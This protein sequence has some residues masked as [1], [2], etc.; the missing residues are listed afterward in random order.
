MALKRKSWKKISFVFILS[1][2]IA[3]LAGLGSELLMRKSSIWVAWILLFM[4]IGI[5][6]IFDIIGIAATAAIE[7]PHHAKA[8]N[9][10]QGAKQ[11]V[12]LLRNADFVANFCNDIIGDVAG[13][14]SGAMAASILV[15]LI[16]SYPSLGNQEILWNTFLLALVASLTITG[17]ALGKSLAINEADEI[18]SKVGALI[19]KI[20]EI[21]GHSFTDTKKKG[22]KRNGD[23]RKD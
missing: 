5:S 18:M 3:V 14:L 12:Y 22:G 15:D 16:R 21:T 13:T 17:K 4:I 9:R 23:S 11:T 8:A 19:A 1:F 6:I 20:E 10:V 7:K 2:A